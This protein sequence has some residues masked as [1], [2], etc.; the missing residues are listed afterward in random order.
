MPKVVHCQRAPEGSVVYI[1]RKYTRG[2]R[3]FEESPFANP[4]PLRRNASSEERAAC[5]AQFK[6]MLDADPVLQER[7]RRELRGHDLGYWCK[8]DGAEVACHGDVLLALANA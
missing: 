6:A 2:G 5:I 4:F 3:H 7:A 1:G 8:K